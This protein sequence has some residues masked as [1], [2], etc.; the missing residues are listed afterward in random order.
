MSKYKKKIVLAEPLFDNKKSIKLLKE[1]IESNFVSEGELTKVFEKKIS[2]LLHIKY[3]SCVTSGTIAI[4][5][6]LKS[7]RIKNKD[8]VLVPNL[9]YPGTL[10][11]VNL[12]GAKP[13]LVDVNQNNLLIDINDLKRKINKK[14]RAI[15]AVHLSGRGTNIT[16]LNKIAKKKKIHLI[17]DAAE[18]FMSK[19]NKKFLGTFGKVGC[20]SFA[21]NKILTTGQGGAVVTNDK[22]IFDEILKLKDQ[23]RTGIKTGGEDSYDSIGYNFKFTNLQAALGLSQLDSIKKRIEKLKNNYKFYKKGIIQN[24]KIKIFSFELQKGEVPLWT[25]IKCYNR[26]KLFNYL[27]KRNIHARYFWH[28]INN[29][30]P[31]KTSSKKFKNSKNLRGKLMWLPSSLSLTNKQLQKICKLINRFYKN[32]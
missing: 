22:K 6:A 25:D 11:A 26:N 20:F 29:L 3:V 15:I 9:T 32:N 16:E 23:G 28:F 7:L 2:K 30:K 31:Y 4:F 21:P 18:A 17:E 13:I 8:E 5:I 19:K 10:N 1:V 27:K 12:A 14:T 24:N